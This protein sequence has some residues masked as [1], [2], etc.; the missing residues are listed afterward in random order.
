MVYGDV[1]KRFVMIHIPAPDTPILDAVSSAAGRIINPVILEWNK[2]IDDCSNMISNP[3]MEAVTNAFPNIM[4]N[5]LVDTPM[6]VHKIISGSKKMG[7]GI[8]V[9]LFPFPTPVDEIYGAY[10]VTFGFRS[11]VYGIGALFNWEDN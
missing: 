4:D 8:A 7:N 10:Q 9:L 11:I 3:S 2:L 6:A 1:D 5:E